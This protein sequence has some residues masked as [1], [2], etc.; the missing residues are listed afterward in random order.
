M[1]W[2]GLLVG[3]GDDLLS[4]VLRDL[5][6][7]LCCGVCLL[8]FVVVWMLWFVLCCLFVLG[9]GCGSVIWWFCAF[10]W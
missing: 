3:C 4:V 5:F 7:G 9:C 10:D 1:I 6:W 2:F 8:S